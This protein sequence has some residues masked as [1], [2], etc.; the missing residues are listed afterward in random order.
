MRFTD[1]HC[2]LDFDEFSSTYSQL[3]GQCQ[4]TGIHRIIVPSISP[5]NWDKVLN[6]SKNKLNI[7]KKHNEES[8]Q[9]TK[10][11]LIYPCLGIHPWFLK[12]LNESHLQNLS[13]QVTKQRHNIIAIGETGIDNV[14]AK[15]QE[16]L[17]QQQDFFSYQLHLAKEHH[18]PVIVH[19]RQS[20]HL[21]M[22]LL[23]QIKLGKKGVI[24]AFSGSYQQAKS[25]IELGF[26]L[27]V[28]GT[29]TYSRASKT[30]NAIKRVPLTSLL[31][32]TD[33]PAMPLANFQGEANSPLKLINVFQCLTQIREETPEKIAEQIENN[34]QDLFFTNT[35]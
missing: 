2:H 12:A 14:I 35:R 29:I 7:Q 24:H 11:C 28:G 3:L 9:G 13:E 25:Y 6:L 8:A 17:K 32:E 1:S 5:D 23:K 21:I 19:H 18:L 27:G 4:H 31:L 33:A 15:Q 20:H 30:I 34:V 26:K 22:P 10:N 16:N